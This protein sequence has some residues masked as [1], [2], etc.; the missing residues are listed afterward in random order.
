MDYAGPLT[1]RTY[2]GRGAKTYKGYFIIFV[3][4]STS[5]I[6]LEVSTDYSTDGFLAAYKRFTGR[7]GLCSTIT[8]DCGTNLVGADEELKRLFDASSNEWIRLATLLANDGV[9]WKFN[10]PSAPHFGEKWE[11]G[12]KSVK[13][14]F[15]RV[16]GDATLTYEEL[17]TLL[18]QIEAILNSRPLTALTDDPS[19]I[20]ALTPGHFLVG[21]ALNTIPEPTLQDIPQ[22]RLS[23]LQLLRQMTESFWTRWSSEYLQQLQTSSKWTTE[24]QSFHRGDLVLIKDERFPPSKWPLARIIDV[25]PGLDGLVR[26]VTVKTA[27]TTLKRPIVKLCL[28]PNTENV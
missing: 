24:K 17:T 19:D 26:V 7:R 3:C 15:R 20:S 23:R 9:T 1:L 8:S 11:A 27:T 18:A 10:P 16:L 4:L 2:R 22:N 21:S 5:A 6:H 28:L 14:H 12:V 25:H 13:H